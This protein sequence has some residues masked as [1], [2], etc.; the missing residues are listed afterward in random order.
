[1]WKFIIKE[2]GQGWAKEAKVKH[3]I[4]RQAGNRAVQKEFKVLSLFWIKT[5]QK[6]LIPAV[7]WQQMGSGKAS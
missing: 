4:V 7:C 3:F 5:I 6:V 2:N 1:L